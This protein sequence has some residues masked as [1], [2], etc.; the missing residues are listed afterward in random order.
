MHACGCLRYP[1]KP[2]SSFTTEQNK[3]NINDEALEV[4][5][6]LLQYDHQLRPTCAE[7]MQ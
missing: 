3:A 7:A 6:H 4:L 5:D 1:R 2:W